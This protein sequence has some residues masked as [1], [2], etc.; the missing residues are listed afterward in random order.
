MPNWQVALLRGINVGKAKRVSMAELKTLVE[1]LGYGDVKTLLNSGNVVFTSRAS[2][3]AAA[4]KIEKA[5]TKVTGVAARVTVLSA[6]ELAAAVKE[7]PLLK[8]AE[9]HS[10]LLVAVLND[11]AD[12]AK[13]LPLTKEDWGQEVF[14]LGSRVAYIWCADGILESKAAVALGKAL[15]DGVTSRNWAT[16]LKLHAM[17]TVG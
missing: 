2:P 6:D 3:S 15:R 14:A 13:L 8:V 16:I 9:N 4:A 5:L 1:E 11:P 12:R 10:Q 17:T 7:N